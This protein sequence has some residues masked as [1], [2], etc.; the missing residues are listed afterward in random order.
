MNF[1]FITSQII[2]E[3]NYYRFGLDYV[4]KI[5]SLTVID[6]T[7]LIYPKVF[8]K[9]KKIEKVGLKKIQIY[10]MDDLKKFFLKLDRYDFII[11]IIGEL[12]QDNFFI[13]SKLKLVKTKLIIFALNT[14]PSISSKEKK[15]PIKRILNKFTRERSISGITK[16]IIFIIRSRLFF[17]NIVKADYIIICG[18]EVTKIF[19]LLV[20]RD[21][22]V[23]PSC[24]YDYILSRKI[25][26]KKIESPYF[27]FLDENLIQHTDFISRN[28]KVEI[29]EL[30]YY[31]LKRF[32]K[33]LNKKF[34]MKI[35]IAAHPRSNI[36]YTK[37]KFSEFEV[38]KNDTANLVKYCKACITS[39]STS[40]NFA[41]I[42]KKPIIF[43]TT[44]RMRKTRPAVEILANNFSKSPL[45]ISM[46]NN[47]NKVN[48][49]FT[50][51]DDDYIK[52]F[53]NYI[54]C[55]KNP[56]F[57][58]ESIEKEFIGKTNG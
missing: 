19:N 15:A 23:V 40:S 10:N 20:N 2:D 57:G 26:I 37:N 45:N 21:T 24:S 50:I 39:A 3:R 38:Y 28:E 18:N 43:I 8:K 46:I 12:N 54:S 51:K 41:V 47:F 16:K 33:Y 22:K 36:Y 53:Y 14:F 9:N 11:S 49:Y 31:E 7:S 13:Y 6:L 55:S 42:F 5:G 44:N 29:E 30:Y 58:L 35:V 25:D 27:L 1:L 34:K 56:K 17:W 4:N 48:N 52:Y 32:F